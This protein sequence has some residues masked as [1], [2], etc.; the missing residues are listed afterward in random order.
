[1]AKKKKP[2]KDVAS[3]VPPKILKRLNELEADYKQLKGWIEGLE[4]RII[5]LEQ[6]QEEGAAEEEH[7]EEETGAEHEEN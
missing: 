1:M 7:Q 3:K 5:Q 4:D 6:P 2:K